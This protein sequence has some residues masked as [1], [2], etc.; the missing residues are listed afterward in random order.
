MKLYSNGLDVDPMVIV[1]VPLVESIFSTCSLV[2]LSLKRISPFTVT[3][4]GE[5]EAISNGA[6]CSVKLPGKRN[7]KL[8]ICYPLRQNRLV[9]TSLDITCPALVLLLP[10]EIRWCY[11]SPNKLCLLT[12]E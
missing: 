7:R 12:M 6:V 10:E 8:S 5:E 3:L 11:Y 1:E 4:S 2:I 9:G